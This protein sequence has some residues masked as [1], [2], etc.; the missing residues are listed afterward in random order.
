MLGD[1]FFGDNDLSSNTN[2]NTTKSNCAAYLTKPELARGEAGFVG[3]F[4]QYNLLNQRWNMLYEF[5]TANFIYESY[6]K[7]N[8]IG[9]TFG[10]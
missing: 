8:Y 4:N 3:L 10:E 9:F 7:A 2:N 6:T 5:F 1:L